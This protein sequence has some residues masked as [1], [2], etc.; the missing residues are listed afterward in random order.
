MTRFRLLRCEVTG[1]L[2]ENPIEAVLVANLVF[3]NA[4]HGHAIGSKRTINAPGA[5]YV[6]FNLSDPI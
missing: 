4:K 3:P 2:A 1:E 5:T 6:T